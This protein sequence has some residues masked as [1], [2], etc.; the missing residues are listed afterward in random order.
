MSKGKIIFLNGASSSGKTVI[1]E[2][3]QDKLSEPYLTL[4]V[5][6]FM[7]LFLQGYISGA[8]GAELTP[9][10]V[11]TLTALIPK[12][13]SSFHQCIAV[14]ADNGIHVIVDHVLQDPD[15]LKACVEALQGF[16]VLFVGVRC[17]LEVLEKREQERER[18]PGTARKQFDIVHAHGVYDLEVDTSLQSPEEIAELIAE[19]ESQIS[20]AAAFKKLAEELLV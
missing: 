9:E 20:S 8:K 6:G 11:Q 12:I 16:P 15:W 1:A 4:S 18:E 19:R 17:P 2:A 5:D 14:F 7:D 3:L 10:D 13:V